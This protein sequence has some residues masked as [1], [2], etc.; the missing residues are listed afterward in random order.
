MTRCEYASVLRSA[1]FNDSLAL[2]SECVRACCSWSRDD[3]GAAHV[4]ISIADALSVDC[5]SDDSIYRN[6]RMLKRLPQPE[7]HSSFAALGEPETE[8][9]RTDRRIERAI[10][11]AAC[12]K[13][14]PCGISIAAHEPFR[15]RSDIR[16]YARL[17]LRGEA[18]ASSCK[19][20]TFLLVGND[21]IKPLSRDQA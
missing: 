4:A 5:F 18:M 9:D 15:L 8:I 19:M 6:R 2:C 21:A 13:A 7:K 20:L 11:A 12:D 3:C 10:N 16:H 17:R 1:C 14:F